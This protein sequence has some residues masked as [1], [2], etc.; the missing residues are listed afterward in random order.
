MARFV[1]LIVL[2]FILVVAGTIRAQEPTLNVV[3]TTTLI[4][5]VARNVGG[6][7]VAVTALL[8]ANADSHAYQPTPGDIVTVAEAD[9]L[10]VN[11]AGYEAFLNTLLDNAALAEVVVVSDGVTVREAGED[12]P[13]R[14]L[15]EETTC[16]ADEDHEHEETEAEGEHEHGPCD[17][18]VW[19]NPQNVAI[20]TDNMAEA[21]AAA[22]PANADTYR[23]NADTYKQQLAALDAEIE[24]MVSAIPEDRRVL[25]TNHEFLG[26]FAD[27]YGFEVVGTVLPGVTTGIEPSPQAL[28]ALIELVEAEGVSAIFAEVSANSQLAEVVA[29][30]TGIDVVTTLYS[31]SLSEADGPAAT[32]LD[33]MRTNAQTIVDALAGAE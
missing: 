3:A 33:F 12:E 14:V 2:A 18:H 20:W 26:Y 28:T 30:E 24:Q 1:T 15:G 16:E 19:M 8:P 32:Y 10:L 21:F 17:P 27:R 22:D 31:E 11:G 5:D 7:L 29:Q 23:A 4:A 9:L 6:D 13:G 25:V